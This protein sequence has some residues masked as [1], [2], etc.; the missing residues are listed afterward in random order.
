MNKSIANSLRLVAAKAYPKKPTVR[1]QL[2]RWFNRLS[3]NQKARFSRSARLVSKDG[4]RKTSLLYCMILKKE[5]EKQSSKKVRPRPFYIRAMT[6]KK[7]KG[8]Q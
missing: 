5:S 4:V 6:N 2:K 1:R 7:Y 3:S 8:K